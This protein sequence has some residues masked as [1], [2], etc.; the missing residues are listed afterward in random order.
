MWRFHMMIHVVQWSTRHTLHI[1]Y[2]CHPSAVARNETDSEFSDSLNSRLSS[3][4]LPQQWV[5]N[6]R[7]I[8]KN[9]KKK[10]WEVKYDM[11]NSFWLFAHHLMLKLYHH[12]Q[13]DDGSV[14]LDNYCIYCRLKRVVQFHTRIKSNKAPANDDAKTVCWA[15]TKSARKTHNNLK[16]RVK[17]KTYL[18][19]E[20]SGYIQIYNS[21]FQLF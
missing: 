16:Y 17:S 3:T 7:I 15:S 1:S 20:H 13:S 18:L 5:K 9:R 2:Y 10:Y 19:N 12:V 8:V 4:S 11:C 14:F 21:K 6:T